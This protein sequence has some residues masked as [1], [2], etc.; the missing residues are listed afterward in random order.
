MMVRLA[1]ESD[2][3]SCLAIQASHNEQ[4]F[5]AQDFRNSISDPNAILLVA[6]S[7]DG[8]VVGFMTGFVVPTRYE[9]ALVHSTM[10]NKPLEGKGI[11][12]P[13]VGFFADFAFRE[14]NVKVIYAEVEDGPDKFYET[15][16]FRK[17][18]EWHSMRL[19]P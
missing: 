11:G 17:V 14:R 2:I 19:L 9:E 8:A 3:A 15:C 10:V 18:H 6:E 16:G 13:L 5:S 4:T 7:G 1:V 12:R